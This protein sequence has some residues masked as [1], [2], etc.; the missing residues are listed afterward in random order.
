[1]VHPTE[2]ELSFQVSKD[3]GHTQFLQK[4]T[5]V[6][7]S[8]SQKVIEEKKR[9]TAE[10]TCNQKMVQS[11]ESKITE[12]RKVTTAKMSTSQSFSSEET[13]EYEDEE[14]DA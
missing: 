11:V 6:E 8:I 3:L 7:G 4:S 13:I 1:M 10:A 12:N 5:E 9:S 14:V 2:T